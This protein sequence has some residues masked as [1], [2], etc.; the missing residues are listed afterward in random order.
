MNMLVKFGVAINY[1]FEQAILKQHFNLMLS[2]VV[3]R[4]LALR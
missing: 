1:H 4:G 3:L 2:L